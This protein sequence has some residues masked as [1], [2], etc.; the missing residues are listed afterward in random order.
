MSILEGLVNF[1][2]VRG[3]EWKPGR[4]SVLLSADY[5]LKESEEET[6]IAQCSLITLNKNK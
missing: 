1:C 6:G 4:P 3:H 5:A 2:D